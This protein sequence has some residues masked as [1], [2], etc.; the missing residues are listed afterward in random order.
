MRS[1][2]VGEPAIGRQLA[3]TAYELGHDR[4]Q[5]ESSSQG[6]ARQQ[7]GKLTDDDLALV[8]GKRDELAWIIHQPLV[9]GGF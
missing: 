8:K 6:K 4:R 9:A 3:E 5:L 1:G 7:W 2:S